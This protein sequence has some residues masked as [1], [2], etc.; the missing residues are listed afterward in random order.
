M[1]SKLK[2]FITGKVIISFFILVSI[3]GIIIVRAGFLDVDPMQVT[4]PD[5]FIK[6]GLVLTLIEEDEKYYLKKEYFSNTGTY[7]APATEQQ[8]SYE[9]YSLMRNNGSYDI[10]EK[11]NRHIINDV[12]VDEYYKSYADGEIMAGN[13]I[14]EVL[15]GYFVPLTYPDG[16]R[17]QQT[18]FINDGG[19]F[20]QVTKFVDSDGNYTKSASYRL[21]SQYE[22]EQAKISV[23]YDFE[24]IVEWDVSDDGNTITKTISYYDSDENY[25]MR[26]I[27]L[28]LTGFDDLSEYINP[29]EVDPTPTPS[30]TT[31][32][33]TSP[34]TSPTPSVIVSPTIVIITPQPTVSLTPSVTVSPSP[35]P[36][37]TTSPTTTSTPTPS[38]WAGTQVG[39]ADYGGLF[40]N[41][42]SQLSNSAV[43]GNANGSVSDPNM[44]PQ[45]IQGVVDDA[46]NFIQIDENGK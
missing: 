7:E 36:S 13:Y 46:G 39:L 17:P 34:T 42:V 45:V 26:P 29:E 4:P 12:Y 6:A 32:P 23:D 35:S 37:T 3:V 43:D 19:I 9:D 11:R 41:I 40:E 14:A 2:N 20:Y 31:T 24:E 8:I 30:P 18:G 38:P 44:E 21:L 5:S 27:V 16:H 1:F 33:T 25:L 22:Y 28:Q 15:D 10:L